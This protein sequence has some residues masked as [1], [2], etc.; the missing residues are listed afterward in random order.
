MYHKVTILGN[1][2]GDPEMRYTP[3]GTAVTN[4]NVATTTKVSKT[5]NGEAVSCPN[6]WKESYNGKNW[7]LTT[8]WR[9]TT[10][11]QLAE[12][13][14]QFLKKGSQVYVEGEVGGTATD[15]SQN[16]TVWTGQ[17]GTARARYEITAR[18]LKFVGSRG[19]RTE[20]GASYEEPEEPPPGFV[21]ESEIPF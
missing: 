19:G 7:E 11:R 1:L 13:C 10:W 8:W 15:G 5:R 20:G 16:P 9:V 14:N 21:E 3:G 6:G 17:D 4:F 2:G 18:L 12:T